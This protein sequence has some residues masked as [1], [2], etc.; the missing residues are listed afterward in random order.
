VPPGAS[1]ERLLAV[2]LAA[3]LLP[4]MAPTAEP[5]PGPSP[6]A[7]TVVAGLVR[8]PAA[9]WAHN[10]DVALAPEP[11]AAAQAQAPRAP[12][13]T[14]EARRSALIAGAAVVAYRDAARS[15]GSGD[16]RAAVRA[17]RAEAIAA[18]L[19]R[20]WRLVQQRAAQLEARARAARAGLEAAELDGLGLERVLARLALE[21]DRAPAAEAVVGPA[22]GAGVAGRM[23]AG[24]AASTRAPAEGD[25]AASSP[26]RQPL[27]LPVDGTLV[28]RF[29]DPERGLRS[30][31]VA[32]RVDATGPVLAPCAGRVMFARSFRSL[33]LLLIIR[34]A[35]GYHTLLAGMSR[36]DVRVGQVVGRGQPVGLMAVDGGVNNRLYME[37]RRS[38]EPID[39]MPSLA[40][41]D[42][43]VRG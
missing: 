7:E 3:W 4:G 16:A 40:A 10:L 37:L 18:Q 39:P 28:E 24:P 15:G 38:G 20:G 26:A 31:G 32:F 36:L 30:R 43:K 19:V 1:A 22:D 2:A 6:A 41:R 21:R 12:S 35:D 34:H 23:A 25:I 5:A 14:A 8:A 9:A 27:A 42:G 33:G 17:A 29:G 13:P 11:P